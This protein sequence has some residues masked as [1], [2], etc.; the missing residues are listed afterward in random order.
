MHE[1]TFSPKY[2]FV[3]L[4]QILLCLQVGRLSVVM[5][6]QTHSGSSNTDMKD[7]P[8]WY[9]IFVLNIVPL[10]ASPL[11]VYWWR[12]NVFVDFTLMTT[13]RLKTKNASCHVKETVDEAAVDRNILQFT[14][15]L[16]FIIE[17]YSVEY[18]CDDKW[19]N[20]LLRAAALP[21]Q[22]TLETCTN[23]PRLCKRSHHDL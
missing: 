17:L 3:Y 5:T 10:K 1:A 22:M 15:Q 16:E 14:P 4:P 18:K 9:R 8:P 19:N 23:V 2:V 13:L 7:T 21:E 6:T 11:L 12:Q 20:K